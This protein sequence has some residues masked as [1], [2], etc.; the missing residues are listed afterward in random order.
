LLGV[1]SSSSTVL[2]KYSQHRVPGALDAGTD[3]GTVLTYTDLLPTDIPEDFLIQG[4][5]SVTV[6]T[7]A[8]FLMIG[9]HDSYFGDNVDPDH[10]L[11]VQI[12]S[13]PEP[14][15]AI[16]CGLG[17]AALLTKRRGTRG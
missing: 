9:V 3:F 5:I 17:V 13:V 8:A 10:D 1:F 14:A 2:D 16:T 12:T 6:P 4:A 15:T 7:G 11:S